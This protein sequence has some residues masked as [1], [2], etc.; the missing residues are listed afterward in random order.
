MCPRASG[1]ERALTVSD[2]TIGSLRSSYEAL[3]RTGE[4][5]DDGL[6]ASNFELRQDRFVEATTIPRGS[7]APGELLRRLSA[8]FRDISF[9]V[10]RL[11]EAPHGEVVVIVRTRALGQ[12]SGI[13][14]DKR[15]AHVWRFADGTATR[16]TVYG[17]APE[18][19]KAVGLAE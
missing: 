17:Q 3:C 9:E 6:L 19:L 7:D 4:W 14:V 15:Q 5:P 8:A 2:D 11:V 16:M 10:E 12:G 1:W 18:A 13:A